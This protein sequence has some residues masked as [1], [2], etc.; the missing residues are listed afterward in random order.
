LIP[1]YW[2]KFV[3]SHNLI[4]R[5]FEIEEGSDLSELGADI[6]IM[7]NEQTLSEAT[8]CYPGIT[9]LKEGYIPI[10][11]CTLGSGDY[12]YINK[13]EGSN[14]SLY[15]IYHDSVNQTSINKDAIDKVLE[16]YEELLSL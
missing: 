5:D 16:N 10:G 8:T 2:L 13:N 15:R 3:E 12:Y 11:M 4:G 9:V 14:G 7:T 6:Q 1:E